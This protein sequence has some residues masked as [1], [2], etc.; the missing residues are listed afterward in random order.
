MNFF[1]GFRC[2]VIAKT[3]DEFSICTV[4]KIE[5]ILFFI[6]RN[7]CLKWKKSFFFWSFLSYFINTVFTVLALPYRLAC[8][9]SRL[10]TAFGQISRSILLS[11]AI[12]YAN[13][14][15]ALL[16]Y[17][18]KDLK[19]QKRWIRLNTEKLRMKYEHEVTRKKMHAFFCG[20]SDKCF[21]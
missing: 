3:Y 21:G 5:K 10:T 15:T 17:I 14:T 9:N 19:R 4:V 6:K 2:V 13:T 18:L 8:F 12:S 16:G 20:L 11:S 1:C 7:F